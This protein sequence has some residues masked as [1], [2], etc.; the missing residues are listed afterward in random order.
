[1]AYGAE[2]EIT[3]CVDFS[4]LSDCMPGSCKA[5]PIVDGTA[6][7]DS[8]PTWESPQIKGVT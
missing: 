1:V 3:G 5:F 8:S 4:E 7:V 6:E 2:F